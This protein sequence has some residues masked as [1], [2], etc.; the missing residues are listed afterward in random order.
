MTQ[1]SSRLRA[2]VVGSG[3]RV[4]NAFLPALSLLDSRIEVVGIHSRTLANARK[5]GERWGVEAIEDPRVLRPGDIDLALVS[6]TVTNNLT[7]LKSLAHLA[8]GAALVIDTPGVGRLDD[9]AR[10]AQ[11]RRWAQIRVGEDFMNMPQYRLVGNAIRA[12]AL[13][14][15]SRVALSEMGY[16]YHALALV[17]S[18]LDLLPPS[19]ARSRR[20]PG[21]VDIDY[22]FR[23]GKIGEVHE[24]YRQG[25][26]SFVV[27][28]SK[29]VLAG[30]PMGHPIPDTRGAKLVR[31]EDDNGLTGFEIDGLGTPMKIGLPYH[32]TLG[33]MGLEDDSEFNLL[34]IDGLSQVIASLWKTGGQERSDPGSGSDPVNTRYRL[35]DAVAD[36]LVSWAARAI[37]WLPTPRL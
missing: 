18:W 12:G 16:R 15:V 8:P 17:R 19:S 6:V 3:Y 29:A 26:G 23:G 21:G 14:E 25:E 24:P 36:N 13:G 5:A 31:I 33:A 28:G 37:P 30:H 1:P 9:L 32:A 2:L 7:V 22:R 11:F 20:V 35:E 4:R 27:T 34:R 10:M